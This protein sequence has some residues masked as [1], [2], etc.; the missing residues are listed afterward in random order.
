MLAVKYY[1]WAWMSACTP[2]Y[3]L[4]KE[5]ISSHWKIQFGKMKSLARVMT[6]LVN[7]VT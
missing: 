6:A 3:A 2:A 7:E 1:F 5:E 4:A